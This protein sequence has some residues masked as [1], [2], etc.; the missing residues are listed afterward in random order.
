MTMNT[1]INTEPIPR[2]NAGLAPNRH[3][4]SAITKGSNRRAT[5]L[6]KAA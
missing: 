6:V 3:S 4:N 1:A 2:R 5:G